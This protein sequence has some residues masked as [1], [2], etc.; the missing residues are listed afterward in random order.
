M[1]TKTDTLAPRQWRD[2]DWQLIETEP[3]SPQ[4]HIALDEVLLNEVAAGRRAPTLRFW[5]WDRSAIVLGVFQSVKN[6]VDLEAC[7][8]YGV[9]VVRRISGGGAMFVEPGNGITYSIY[10]PE[11]LVA[12]MSLSHAYAYLDQ[13]VLDAF[14]TLGIKAW[15]QPLNDL[16]SEA[17]KIGGAA[18]TRRRGTVL[19]HVMMAYNMDANRMTEVLRIGREKLSDKGTQSAAKRVDPIRRQTGMSRRAVIEQLTATFRDKHGL[20]NATVTSAERKSMAQL[21]TSKFST[22]SWAYKVP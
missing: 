6:E 3:L 9:E 15:Y 13:W 14:G 8:K 7:T 5:D 21:I 11:S 22:H 1:N 4:Q 19:H 10:A 12:N 18:Q 20:G 17:G 2:F 16:T